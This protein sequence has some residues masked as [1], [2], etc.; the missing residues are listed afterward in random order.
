MAEVG[1][2]GKIFGRRYCPPA[3]GILK[4]GYEC[5][6]FIDGPNPPIPGTPNYK[7]RLDKSSP[8]TPAVLSLGASR[9]SQSLRGVGPSTCFAHVG[10]TYTTIATTT[11]AKGHAE[12]SIALPR[13]RGVE[14][15]AQWSI[16]DPRRSTQVASSGGLE[17]KLR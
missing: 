2:D 6:G 8:F 16:L 12:V 3:R 11:N 14:I 13:T 4:Y 9:I 7:V 10:G 1:S 15:Y 5:H 17:I